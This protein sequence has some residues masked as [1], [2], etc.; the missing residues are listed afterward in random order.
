MVWS[1]LTSTSAHVLPS[2]TLMRNNSNSRPVSPASSSIIEV[3][4][5]TTARPDASPRSLAGPPLHDAL[6]IIYL[7]HPHLI[8]GPTGR[9]HVDISKTERDGETTFNPVVDGGEEEQ[10]DAR[11]KAMVLMDLDVQGFFEV[12]LSVVDKADEVV[13]R[14]E[15]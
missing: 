5:L 15:M 4:L 6:T 12:M 1:I 7:T 2:A 3:P 13:A 11:N 9:L 10:G 14:V 8:S